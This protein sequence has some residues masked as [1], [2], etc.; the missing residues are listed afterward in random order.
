M[1]TDFSNRRRFSSSSIGTL[2]VT[3]GLKN[4]SSATFL[5]MSAAALRSFSLEAEA[6]VHDERRN[7]TNILYS[8]AREYPNHDLLLRQCAC[9]GC[10][11]LQKSH[12]QS[13]N[14]LF[15]HFDLSPGCSFAMHCCTRLFGLQL[16]ARRICDP[17]HKSH[18]DEIQRLLLWTALCHFL[19][20]GCPSNS[21]QSMHV[22]AMLISAGFLPWLSCTVPGFTS[23]I[24]APPQTEVNSNKSKA[25]PSRA[26]ESRKISSTGLLYVHAANTYEVGF[27]FELTMM[28]MMVVLVFV[29]VVRVVVV[30][31]MMIMIII[32]IIVMT[33][34][35]MMTTTMMMMMMMMTM[36]ITMM[37]T[38]LLLL[39]LP[40]TFPHCNAGV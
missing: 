34:M 16:R 3:L 6:W 17:K 32:I 24:P 33:M 19:G 26:N 7:V 15:M 40:R 11:M 4:R 35:M 30:V 9:I 29:E 38:M 14:D 1:S 28:M 27:V 5:L 13:F 37:M 23:I 10:N 12:A 25:D 21:S 8:A 39:L 31:M 22:G 18:S 36:S 2:V 20:N